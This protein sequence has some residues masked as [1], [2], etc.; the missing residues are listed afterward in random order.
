MRVRVRVHACVHAFCTHAHA[1]H[2][3][4][5]CPQLPTV[6]LHVHPPDACLHASRARTARLPLPRGTHRAERVQRRV[7]ALPTCRLKGTL[8]GLLCAPP[9][10]ALP[11]RTR[12]SRPGTHA[13]LALATV[14]APGE[15]YK[16]LPFAL[17]CQPPL[18]ALQGCC[19]Q[20]VCKGS[21][22]PQQEAK[23]QAP[24]AS[25]SCHTQNLQRK[26]EV[27]GTC[28][29]AIEEGKASFASIYCWD[30]TPRDS[31]HVS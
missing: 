6:Y 10:A 29:D 24:S 23:V 5:P 19:C 27:E 13:S 9:P 15:F 26:W 8:R 16:W 28:G 20:W 22:P 11:L 30:R 2:A 4:H 1:C 12:A 17:L 18:R 25:S 3:S 21:K 14:R 31:S 7:G